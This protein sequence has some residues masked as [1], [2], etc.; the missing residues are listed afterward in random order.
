MNR[1]IYLI[2]FLIVPVIL[3]IGSSLAGRAES[4]GNRVAVKAPELTGGTG[5]LN[6]DRPIYIKDL[7]GK[8]VLLDFWT[9]CCINCMHV[10]P[11][12]KRLEA[13]YPDEL[14]VIGVHSAKFTNERDSDNIRQAILRY[15]IE[16]PVVNDS[17]FRIWRSYGVR[18]WPTLV[19]INPEG[20]VAGVVSGEGHYEV[21][22]KAISALIAEFSEK[23]EIDKTPLELAPEKYEQP[24]TALSFPG[25][26]LA[27]SVH[28]FA[29]LEG[30]LFISDSNHNRI[31]IADLDGNIID[32]IGS[33]E[34]GTSD[35][36][37]EEATFNKPQ[38]MALDGGYLYVADTENHLIRRCHLET[39]TVETIAG[40]GRQA[41]APAYAG[42]Y[43]KALQTS[44]SSPW[45]L[46]TVDDPRVR[47]DL[48]IAMAGTHQIWVMDL[49][50][51]HIQP[52]AGSGQEG[53]IDGSLTESAL[54][55]P[56]GITRATDGKHLFVA[57]SETSSIRSIDLDENGKVETIVGL[58]LFE[59]GD[60]DG[61][62]REVRLQHP[63]GIL[64][65]KGK[66]YVADTYNHKIKIVDPVKKTSETLL[67]NGKPGN[68]DGASPTFFEPS[69]LGI[70]G[71]KLYIA[72]TNNHAIR[73][74]DLSTK[75]VHVLALK[76]L[77]PPGEEAMRFPAET[78]VLPGRR[79]RAGGN[80]ELILNITLPPPYKLTEDAPL[81]YEIEPCDG[82]LLEF[83]ELDR[84]RSAIA[85][86]LPIKI[87]FRSSDKAGNCRMKVRLMF[88]YC[89]EDAGACFIKFLTLQIPV[90]IT[91][92]DRNQRIFVEYRANI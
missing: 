83:A 73:V 35:G 54:A 25:K 55:Q 91:K 88:N 41:K 79:I 45:D 32:I 49:K 31:V 26:V 10:I 90:Q 62:G 30:V 20:Y 38:G 56:S 50:R 3:L 22:D 48:Y 1:S 87:P 82:D 64:F 15:G 21:L 77:A 86:E 43:G 36:A 34:S 78:V 5:W 33:G 44:L 69:G 6:T 27:S 51:E 28:P 70:S 47:G 4:G 63:L 46:V 14:V 7:K 8:V 66:L 71:N 9:Y 75:L 19:L 58:D 60:R 2:S 89:E 24:D 81:D 76:D 53:R 61:K 85:P 23:G 16:H 80:G 37:F 92:S 59:F 52:Y 18:A 40:T 11:D 84:K 67:G 29:S 12:L 74:A 72:D 68:K 65:H 13:K 39:R 42:G 57:D 17:Q